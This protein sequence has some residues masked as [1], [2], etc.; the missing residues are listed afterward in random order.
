MSDKASQKS[1]N[2]TVKLK[3]P[4]EWSGENGKEVIDSVT[5]F[6][7]R[8]KHIK[9][10]G[11]DVNMSELL[12]IASKISGFTPA[13]FDEMDA[14]D[15]IKITEVIGDFLDVGQGIGETA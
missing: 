3:Y 6:R 8:G 9:N 7:P 15:C 5:L 13:F 10:I 14:V 12:K 4:F 1:H 2:V 11:K